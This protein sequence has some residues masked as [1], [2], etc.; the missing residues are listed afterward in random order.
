VIGGRYTQYWDTAG[1]ADPGGT[2]R[3]LGELGF[4]ADM[5]VSGT[6]D[7]ENPLWHIDGLRHL[8]TPTLSYRYIPN[9][10]KNA[11]WIPEIDRSTFTNYLP[12]MELGDM[13]ALDQLQAENAIR[14]GLNNTLQT[15][16]KTYGS[17]DLLTFNVADDF[18][19]QRA[20]GQT[21]FSDLH[22]ELVATPARWLELRVEDS[23]STVAWTQRA[24]DTTIT[25]KEG[26][27]WSW[28]FGVG[29]LSD[30]YGTFYLPGLGNLPIVGLDIYHAEARA[31][32]N[33]VYTA[34]VRGDY[35][36]R[37]HIFVD[38]FYGFSQRIS[39]TWIV[40]YAVTFSS[41]PNNGQGH[42]GLNATLNMVR[43]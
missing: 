34:F 35:D 25:V 17:T 31:R 6:F 38:Q 19:F 2:G 22:A 11:D 14:I 24:M 33:E 41:G 1:A 32:L 29:Y 7:Y 16:D 18:H 36:A 26:E 12:I 30:S 8:L 5:Q 15:R 3:A 28:G 43:F 20:P 40:E 10:D 39:N 37:D 4:D 23:V 21:D 42:F 13:R 27:V 9:A